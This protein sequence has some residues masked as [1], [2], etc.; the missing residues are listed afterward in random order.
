MKLKEGVYENLINS[1]TAE[2]IHQTE[3][4][5]LVCRK[6]PIDEAEA[7]KLLSQY[8]AE[9]IRR[10]I[11]DSE[12]SLEEKIN[13]ANQI[14][15]K[16]RIGDDEALAPSPQLLSAVINKQLDI[17]LT[18]TK[19]ELVRPLSGF[20][21]SNLFTGGQSCLSIGTEIIR[22][23]ASSDEICI[24][25]SFLRMSG[26]RMMLD[27]LKEFCKVE[28]RDYRLLHLMVQHYFFATTNTKI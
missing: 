5:G 4:A 6:Q 2:D 24:I 28:R 13:F 3:E 7:S 16:A 22:D 8:L 25:V 26:I 21:V 9:S 11:E 12:L 17:N 18:T 19:K 1:R 20:R 10:K 14:L 15:T 23:I 27:T